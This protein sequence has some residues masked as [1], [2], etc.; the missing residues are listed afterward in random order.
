[1]VS[2][3]AQAD[4]A[5]LAR[6]ARAPA[7]PESYVFAKG[8]FFRSMFDDRV[9]QVDFDTMTKTFGADLAPRY[10]PAGRASTAD[11][12]IVVHWGA[13]ARPEDAMDTLLYDPDTLRQADQAI[14]TAK[15]QAAA[16]FKAGNYLAYGQVA[17]AESNFQNELRM[18]DSIFSMDAQAQ[19]SSADLIG[20]RGMYSANDH[21]TDADMARSL[22][23]DDRYFVTLIAYDAGLLRLKQKRVVWSARMSAPVAGRDFATAIRQMSALAAPYY[24]TQQPKMLLGRPAP[25][26]ASAL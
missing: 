17:A 10:V 1:M 22:V 25:P 12:I 24:G 14:D 26:P 21:S 23:D 13:V 11:L 19:A 18:A 6:T 16:D 3:R 7:T 9:N 2:V 20:L 4:P 15:T 5:Y 8:R